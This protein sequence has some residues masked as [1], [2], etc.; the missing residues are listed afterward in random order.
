VK[1]LARG[2]PVPVGFC[3]PCVAGLRIRDLMDKD[4]VGMAG[5]ELKPIGKLGIKVTEGRRE[6]TQE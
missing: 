6:G 1:L 3:R 4:M 5:D 2:H